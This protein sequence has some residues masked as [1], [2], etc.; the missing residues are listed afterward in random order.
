M[1]SD[2][3]VWR[4][5]RP[6]AG[7]AVQWV[8]GWLSDCIRRGIKYVESFRFLISPQTTPSPNFAQVFF[9]DGPT[10]CPTNPRWWTAAIFKMEKLRCHCSGLTNFNEI[11]QYSKAHTLYN[12][13]NIRIF[14][15]P[16]WRPTHSYTVVKSWYIINKLDWYVGE[17]SL[18]YLPAKIKIIAR[19]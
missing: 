18:R 13:W 4:A 6:V 16:I 3:E 10:I 7:Q 1:A 2:R 19:L 5:L 8:S 15:N 17:Q 14:I 12:V 11:W 9:A